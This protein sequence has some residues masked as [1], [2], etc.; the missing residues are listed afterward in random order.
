LRNARAKL[1]SLSS[2][3]RPLL[4]ELAPPVEKTAEVITLKPGIWG[5][6]IDL[7]EATRRLRRYFKKS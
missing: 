2:G 5:M 4:D 1:G 3:E 7:K 6:S